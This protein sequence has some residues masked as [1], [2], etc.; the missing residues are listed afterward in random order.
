MYCLWK[1][2]NHVIGVINDEILNEIHKKIDH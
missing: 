1:Q 2:L